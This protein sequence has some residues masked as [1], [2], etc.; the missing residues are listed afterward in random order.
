MG[1]TGKVLRGAVLD[2]DCRAARAGGST[3]RRFPAASVAV[4]APPTCGPKAL[5]APAMFQ[6]M[7]RQPL[8]RLALSAWTF[9]W[10]TP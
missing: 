6:A 3:R 1:R 10:A 9:K 5:T 8:G 4:G 7:H 2:A